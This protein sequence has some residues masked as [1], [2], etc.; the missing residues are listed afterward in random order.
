MV[1]I[2]DISD[3]FKE[4]IKMGEMIKLIEEDME[5]LENIGV[6]NNDD[7]DI[8]IDEIEKVSFLVLQFKNFY[9]LL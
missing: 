6:N 3:N 2:K 7:F 8:N 5:I 4:T 1:G 9:Y